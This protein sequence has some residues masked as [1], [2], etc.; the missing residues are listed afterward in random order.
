MSKIK[1]LLDDCIEEVMYI[2]STEG[3]DVDENLAMDIILSCNYT[4]HSYHELN[5]MDKYDYVIDYLFEKFT[6]F[7][8]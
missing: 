7:Y 8:S 2:G 5:K 3:F 4:G 6:N 1:C